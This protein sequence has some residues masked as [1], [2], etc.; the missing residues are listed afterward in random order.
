MGPWSDSDGTPRFSCVYEPASASASSPLPMLVYI[1]PSLVNADSVFF[2]NLPSFMDTANLSSDPTKPGFIL[3]APEGRVTT[4]YYPVPDSAGLGWDNWYRQF[5][6]AI[7]ADTE[8]VDAA[9][10][11]HFIAAEVATG[12]VDTNRIFLTGWSNGAAMAYIYALNRTNIAAIAVYSAPDPWRF[13]VDP[14]EQLPVKSAPKNIGQIAIANRKVPTYQ[15]HNGCDIAGLCP[16]TRRME[17]RLRKLGVPVKDQIIGLASDPANPQNQQPAKS[18]FAECG[19]DPNGDGM[20]GEGSFNHNRWPTKWT[21][22]M[23]DFLAAHP[24]STH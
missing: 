24:L 19:T 21:Q 23:L 5:N 16:N 15:V 8:N 17:K 10:I 6:P 12:K 14:C 9:T 22:S 20:N 13:T 2:T 7:T 3:L 11:D 18:C 1:H 4:H